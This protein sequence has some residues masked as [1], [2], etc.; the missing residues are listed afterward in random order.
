MA[1][2]QGIRLCFILFAYILTIASTQA[3]PESAMCSFFGKG[4]VPDRT[5]C[6]CY[7]KCT[8]PNDK[9]C[10]DQGQWYNIRT[11][12]CL[13][14][15]KFPNVTQT[16]CRQMQPGEI[17]KVYLMASRWTFSCKIDSSNITS[18]IRQNC[19]HCFIVLTIMDRETKIIEK[20][21]IW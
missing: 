2:Q 21:K 7:Y 1:G 14:I 9:L 11:E 3:V 6:G 16:K 8:A 15:N 12:T 13:P 4:T 20:Q 18:V 10:C 19:R 5:D 17:H